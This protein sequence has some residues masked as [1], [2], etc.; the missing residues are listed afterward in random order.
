MERLKGKR[1]IITGAA[2]GQGRVACRMFAAEGAR[3]LATDLD[4]GAKAEVEALASSGAIT[5]VAADVASM[6]GIRTIVDAALAAFGGKVDVLYNN[7]G[8]ILG[9]PFME[10]TPEEWDRIHNV[11]LKSVYFLSQRVVPAMG[12]GAS[13]INISSIG[14]LVALENM[15]AYGAAKGGLAMLTRGMAL[16][17]SPRRIRVN[18]ICPGVIDTPMPRNFVRDLPDRERI[19]SALAERHMMRRLGQPEEIV[20]LAV[21]LAS[22]E[23]SFMTGSVVT[24]DGGWTAF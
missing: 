16:D 14:G 24:V 17:L 6:A 7:H 13:I 20:A 19:L 21:F 8:V 9:K 15:T 10:T 2:G 1:A 18:A 4:A 23:S 11:D 22:D 3:V 12:Q 5:Y